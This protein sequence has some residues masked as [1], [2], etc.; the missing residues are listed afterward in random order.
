M[1]VDEM[2]L[3]GSSEQSI[4]AEA[5]ASTS[6]KCTSRKR[7]RPGPRSSKSRNEESDKEDD[8]SAQDMEGADAEDASSSTSSQ[9][10]SRG[11]SRGRP[12]TTGE[13]VG[14]HA[15]KQKAI[16]KEWELERLRAERELAESCAEARITRA[17]AMTLSNAEDSIH[18]PAQQ[19]EKQKLVTD[20]VE[21]RDL[22]IMTSTDLQRVAASDA[23]L[24]VNLA[25]KSKNLKG[26]FQQALKKSAA[27]LLEVVSVLA[28][29][30]KTEEVSR[31]EEE[32]RRLHREM[33]TL[34]VE[35]KTLKEF[36]QPD[37]RDKRRMSSQSSTPSGGLEE[38]MRDEEIF[39]PPLPPSGRMKIN[40]DTQLHGADHEEEAR[41][42]RMMSRA[43]MQMGAMV[44][45][46][47]EA[48][49][50]RLLPE[51]PLRPPLGAE[52]GDGDSHY[53]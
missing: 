30:Q 19:R 25:T 53:N 31:L 11:R 23:K 50:A 7:V 27:S 26:T 1:V 14:W 32:N 39:V 47:F 5:V 6:T 20:N 37:R 42:E 17:T 38:A 48:I 10:R 29:R 44:A 2:P 41:F 16:E 34:K 15:E 49:E 35:V 22:T 28:N 43:M 9:K 3:Q 13:Y 33:E 51:K 4:G 40:E 12:P 24:V 21:V 45:A 8:K 52:E 18:T 46:R 36:V